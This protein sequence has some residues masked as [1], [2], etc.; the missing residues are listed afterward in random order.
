MV[1]V[2]QFFLNFSRS[3]KNQGLK[4]N[5]TAVSTFPKKINSLDIDL[6]AR[7]SPKIQIYVSWSFHKYFKICEESTIVVNSVPFLPKLAQTFQNW[8]Q[9]ERNLPLKIRAHLRRIPLISSPILALILAQF[10]PKWNRIPWKF[11]FVRFIK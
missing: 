4:F 10:W 5:P 11:Y 8:L 1:H 7:K 6:R 3:T 9:M 2:F